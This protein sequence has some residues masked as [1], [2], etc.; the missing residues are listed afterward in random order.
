MESLISRKIA[1]V[2]LGYVGLPLAV[3]FGKLTQVVGFDTNKQRVDELAQ[4]KDSTLETS[5]EE[6][7]GSS[8]LV[9]TADPQVM[10]DCEV[11]I[12]TV[13]T[14]IDSFRRPDLTPLLSAS[15]TIGGMLSAGNVVIYESTT[16]PGCTEE[17]CVPV[18]ERES[19]LTF[20]VDFFVGY[21][22]ERINPGDRNRRLSSIVKVTSGST[23][24]IAELVDQLYLQVITAGTYRAQSIK[25][26]EASKIVENT[27]RDLNISLMNELSL[28][29][30]RMS[31]DT[32]DVLEAAGTKWNFLPFRPGLVGGHCIGVDPYYLKD[33]AE[34]LGYLPE[35]ISA[36]R[37]IND[38]MARYVAQKAIK[39][40][41]QKKVDVPNARVGIQGVTFKEDCPDL[42][43]SKVIDMWA[44]FREY[45]IDPL[46]CDPWVSAGDQSKYLPSGVFV[47]QMS[48][49]DVLIV[50]VGHSCFRQQSARKLLGMFR[51]GKPIIM[52][53][54]G[55]YERASLEEQGALVW[56]L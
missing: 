25:V 6:L 50:A 5:A 36:G 43:N 13:P 20:N 1:V 31:I 41:V 11:Y 56:R 28:I 52:D 15:K 17:D 42:R 51:G 27:Q 45:G 35:V 14:P 7:N 12:V 30:D 34:K 26:A 21:S 46:V 40:M 3:E 18:L 38:E 32:V 48:D 2:G 4:G 23:P 9:V 47:E 19:G 55:L 37:R 44:E 33:K 16:Y 54:K 22:P 29:F 24:E 10:A 8:G 53:L 39:L 49:L